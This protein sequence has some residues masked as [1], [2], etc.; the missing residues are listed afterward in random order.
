M[1]CDKCGTDKDLSLV[2][3]DLGRGAFLKILCDTCWHRMQYRA[4]LI[5]RLTE[6]QDADIDRYYNAAKALEVEQGGDPWAT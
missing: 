4:E 3:A 2:C 5:K 6:E 1:G